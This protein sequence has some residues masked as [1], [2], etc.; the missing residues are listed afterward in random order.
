MK[1]T[2]QL[3]LLRL[4]TAY[5]NFAA[6]IIICQNTTV[7]LKR[8]R[9]RNSLQRT[10]TS[11]KNSVCSSFVH[12]QSDSGTP[13]DTRIVITDG[14]ACRS[15]RLPFTSS[16]SRAVAC[17]LSS[18]RRPRIAS[19]LKSAGVELGQRRLF[20]HL[21]LALFSVTVPRFFL[22]Q[23]VEHRYGKVTG[24]SNWW[25]KHSFLFLCRSV[26]TVATVS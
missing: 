6:I 4:T 7:I 18:D 15:N 8:G 12:C 25:A 14:L 3:F 1:N 23:L 21:H 22:V 10:T 5:W 24:E 26:S 9:K 17:L 16:F 19:S 11:S 20:I 2:T 13:R